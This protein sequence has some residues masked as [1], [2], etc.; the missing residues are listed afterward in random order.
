MTTD[1]ASPAGVFEVRDL[2]A[3]Y[4]ASFTLSGISFA[5]PAGSVVGLVGPNGGGKS[6]LL[7]AIAG[8]L[9]P[10]AGAITLDG[11]SVRALAA[12][13]AFVPQREEVNWEFPVTARDVVLMARY[14]DRG[15]LRPPGR[16]D[17][18]RAA[19]ALDRMGLAGREDRHI[20]QFSGG[21]QQRI[22]LARAIAQDPLLVLLDEPFTGVDAENRAVFH[23]AISGFSR[24]GATVLM[25]THDLEEVTFACS[26]VGFLDGRLVAF[27]PTATTFTAENLRATFGGQVAVVS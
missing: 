27:G 21:Q 9:A 23:A 15:W 6:T 16:A 1:A 10:R 26:H 22:F 7:K 12:R 25:A 24:Q 5:V 13:V 18:E 2:V 20:S 19:Q 11:T 17:R 14:R 4:H 3:G 8:V